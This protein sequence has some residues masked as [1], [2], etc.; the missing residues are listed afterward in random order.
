[1]IGLATTFFWIF[2]IAFAVS[3]I[4]SFI[5]DVRFH[6]GELQPPTSLTETNE[7]ILSLPITIENRGF[8]NIGFFNITTEISDEEGFIVTRGNTCITVINRNDVVTINH[9]MTVNVTDLLQKKQN[10]L[11]NDTELKIYEV[12]S[13]T[14]AEIIPFQ[15]S[16]NLSIPWGAPLHNFRLGEPE[17]TVFN[18]THSRV[19]L[20]ISFENHA[21]FDIAGNIAIRMYNDADL[22]VGEGRTSIDAS[23]HSSYNGY[24]ELYV[25]SIEITP[26]GHFEVGFLTSLLD[27]GPLVIPYG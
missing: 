13:M 25:L 7:M 21:F 4:Y 24:V 1:M 27:Y 3:A 5:R 2:L 17:Y 22:L 12:L 9:N 23:K 14:A 8:Y 26:S 18:L 20:P 16:T 15:A 19:T 11:F 6:F 10:F